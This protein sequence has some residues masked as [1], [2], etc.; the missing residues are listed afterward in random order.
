MSRNA[1]P[2]VSVFINGCNLVWAASYVLQFLSKVLLKGCSLV[3]N[4]VSHLECDVCVPVL[5]YIFELFVA[6]HDEIVIVYLVG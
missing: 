3:H 4:Q 6:G 1:I 5:L 2:Q